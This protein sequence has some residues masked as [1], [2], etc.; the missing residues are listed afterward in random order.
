VDVLI[1]TW[2]AGGGSTP[3][4]GLGR[5]LAQLGHRVRLL[6]PGAYADRITAAGCIP[7][8][9]PAGAE[10]DQSLG[11]RMEDQIPYLMELFFGLELPDAVAAE[12]S[13]E[14]ADVLVVDYL[15]RTVACL[16]EGLDIPQVLLIHTIFPFHGVVADEAALRRQYEPFNAARE[17]MQLPPFPVGPDTVTI[18]LARRAARTLVCLPREF[19]PW[20]D[21]PA[22]VVHAGPIAEEAAGADWEQPWSDDDDRPLVVVSMGTTYMSH[23]ELLGRVAEGLADLAAR[24]LVLT[25]H[26][27]APNEVAARE[28]VFVAS[29]VPHAAVLPEASLVVTHAGT[30]TLMAAFSAGVPVVCIPLGRDQYDNARRVEELGLG[31]VLAPEATAWEI[32]QSVENALDSADLRDAAGRM[33]AAID[34]YAGGS[35]AV[36]LLEQLVS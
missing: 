4:I 17:K 22:G 30:G 6:A 35:R 8:P 3:A 31:T 25:G 23:E 34:G 10:F 9:L 21:P 2:Q 19:D 26:E 11:R 15:L 33:A 1:V 14:P 24:V 7:R 12:L 32:R 36:A 5:L 16:A 13:T 20:P 18:A 29:Y 28:G 27:L